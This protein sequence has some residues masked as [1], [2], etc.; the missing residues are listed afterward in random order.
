SAKNAHRAGSPI[1]SMTSKETTMV[2]RSRSQASN[3]TSEPTRPQF[4]SV[5]EVARLCRVSS[6]TLYR[7]SSDGHCTAASTRGRLIVHAK[8]LESMSDAALAEQRAV[9]AAGW[10][11][12][13]G[14]GV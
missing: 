7:A 10:G 13:S 9:D 5:A 8:A 4:Y 12:G 2:E 6:M 11:E 1:Q 14:G 3:P